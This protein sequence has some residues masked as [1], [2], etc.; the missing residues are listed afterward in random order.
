MIRRLLPLL[1]VAL[2]AVPCALA[3]ASPLAGKYATKISHTST[4]LLNANWRVTIAANGRY[5]IARNGQNVVTGVSAVSKNRVT[6]TDQSGVNAC[7]GATATGYYFWSIKHARLTLGAKQD[8]CAGRK[9][10]LT[11]QPF[12]KS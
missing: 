8:S 4:S 5:T 10:V 11:F 12:V 6:F 9:T 7:T 2:V 1:V 3:G